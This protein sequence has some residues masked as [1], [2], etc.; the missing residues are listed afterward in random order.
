[1]YTAELLFGAALLCFGLLRRGAGIAGW[2]GG[3][4]HRACALNDLAIP[5][6]RL[7]YI[8]LYARLI[9]LIVDK[10]CQKTPPN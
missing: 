5:A 3:W 7:H 8:T 1:M 9:I 4:G 6:P 2:V 10:L